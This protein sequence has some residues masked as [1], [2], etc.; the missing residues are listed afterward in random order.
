[1]PETERIL[2]GGEII[3]SLRKRY[4]M[5]IISGLRG[6]RKSLEKLRKITD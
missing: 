3:Y 1:M 6:I 2:E 5:R 4:N